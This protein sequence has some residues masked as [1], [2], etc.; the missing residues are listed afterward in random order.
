MRENWS[1]NIEN[2]ANIPDLVA[3][4][5]FKNDHLNLGLHVGDKKEAVI[6]NRQIVAEALQFPLSKWVCAEQTH[7]DQIVKVDA[8]SAGKGSIDYQS[9]I[10][11]TDGFYTAE[12]DILLTMCYADCVPIFYLSLEKSLIGIVHAGRKGTTLNIAGKMIEVWQEKEQ[13]APEEIQV[14]I[15]PAICGN[16]YEVDDKAIAETEALLGADAQNVYQ[17]IDKKLAARR[18]DLQ[19]GR[20]LL[21]L[22]AVNFYNIINMGVPRQNIEISNYCTKCDDSLF[23]SYRRDHGYTGR[24]MAYMGWNGE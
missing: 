3:G 14:F 7:S 20:N 24:M 5:T 19:S 18:L 6:R 23:F 13:V 1:L 21:D 8:A 17:K 12:K 22:K 10:P 2:W 9:S 11:D 15:G 4:F 16:C